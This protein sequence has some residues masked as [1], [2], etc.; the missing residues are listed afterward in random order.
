MSKAFLFQ[1]IQFSQ[2]VQFTISMPLVLFN[3]SIR[4]YLVLPLR[5]RIELG[6][7][8][9]NGCSVFPKAPA[10]LGPYHQIVWCHIGTLI[11]GGLPLCRGAV[12]V[13]YCSKSDSVTITNIIYIYIYVCMYLQNTSKPPGCNTKSN[14]IQ[15]EF[16]TSELEFSFS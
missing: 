11:G 8:V 4:P 16:N 15:V 1:T 13:F 6:A 12:S 5:T 10:L 9:M 14:F 7:M 3:P 2:T